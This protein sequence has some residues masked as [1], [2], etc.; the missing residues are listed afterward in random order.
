MEEC[1]AVNHRSPVRARVTY[2]C[3]MFFGALARGES[4]EELMSRSMR[5]AAC[6]ARDVAWEAA[7]CVAWEACDR[8]DL[9]GEARFVLAVSSFRVGATPS[10][11]FIAPASVFV[12]L[13]GL[14]RTEGR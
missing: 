7:W 8:K 4:I 12:I 6:R 11:S 3:R 2:S 10:N 13:L 5:L 14:A 9:A 1:A